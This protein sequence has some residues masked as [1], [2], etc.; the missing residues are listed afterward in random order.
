MRAAGDDSTVVTSMKF[1]FDLFPVLVFFL[2]FKVAGIY[3]ATGAAIAAS[4]G[5]IAWLLLRRKKVDPML[6]VS[7]AIVVIFGGATLILHD[8]TFIKWKPT[9][10]FWIFGVV[11]VGGELLFRKNLIRTVMEKQLTLPENVWPWLNRSWA[12]FF[13]LLGG[14]NLYFALNYPTEVW[15]NFKLIGVYALMFVFV[16]AQGLMLSKYVVEEKKEDGL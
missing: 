9:V 15:V 4:V 2:A 3:A 1:L 14:M 7:F 6:W 12:A 13:L 5:Q 16:V 10:L 11:L 8:E